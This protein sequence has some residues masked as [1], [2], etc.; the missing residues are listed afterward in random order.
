M[1]LNGIP[2]K[3]E[4]DTGARI[5][6]VGKKTWQE[7]LGSPPLNKRKLVLRTYSGQ[8]LRVLG[9]SNVQVKTQAATIGGGGGRG[10]PLLRNWLVHV[11]LA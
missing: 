1:E 9:E 6:L 11:E 2:S 8:K 3:M 10:T 5:S 4:L 7:K